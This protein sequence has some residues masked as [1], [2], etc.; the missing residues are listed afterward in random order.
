MA[1]GYGQLPH[2]DVEHAAF[3]LHV[4]GGALPLQLEDDHTAVVTRGQQVLLR[5]SGKD[6][7]PVKMPS[8]VNE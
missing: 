4:V 7:E 1:Y 6:P 5:V 2:L 8:Q 3:S